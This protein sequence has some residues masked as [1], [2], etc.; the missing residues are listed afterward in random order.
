MKKKAGTIKEALREV[1]A[2]DGL[3]VMD[4]FMTPVRTQDGTILSDELIGYC[5]YQ[6]G[7]LVPEDGDSY[8]I[9]EKIDGFEYHKGEE[10]EEDYLVVWERAAA[11]EIP[12]SEPWFSMIRDGKKKEEYREIKPYWTSRFRKLFPFVKNTNIHFDSSFYRWFRL[13]NGYGKE[14]PSI[15]THVSLKRGHGKPEWGAE[16]G[17]EYYVLTIHEVCEER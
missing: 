6:A 2:R 1:G 4:R 5:R 16:D 10:G 14:R 13:R 15:M 3:L 8:D 12:V 7:I 17:K 11:L 9:D